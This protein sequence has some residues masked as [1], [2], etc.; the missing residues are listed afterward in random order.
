MKE[1]K[2]ISLRHMLLFPFL[3]LILLSVSVVGMVS[4]HSGNQAVGRAADR[5]KI[6]SGAGSPIT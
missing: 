2:K 6:E 3:G 1:T 4:M 5:L